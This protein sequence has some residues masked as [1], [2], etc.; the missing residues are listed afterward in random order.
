MDGGASDDTGILSLLRRKVSKII[1]F[2]AN[3]EELQNVIGVQNSEN[4][5]EDNFC[6]RSTDANETSLGCIAGLFGR[7]KSKSLSVDNISDTQYNAMRKVFPSDAWDELVSGL[8]K[9]AFGAYENTEKNTS[10]NDNISN[11]NEDIRNGHNNSSSDEDKKNNTESE[12]NDTV[13]Q[14]TNENQNQSSRPRPAGPLSY[15]LRTRV[16]PNSLICVPGGHEA[17]ILFIINSYSEDWQSL[18]P[19]DVQ[20]RMKSDNFPSRID[21]DLMEIGVEPTN[22]RNFPYIPITRL[23]YSPLLVGLLSQ[24]AS[25][26]VMQ[27]KNE[28]MKLLS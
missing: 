12:T 9:K 8:R 17:E 4:A 26:S 27:S 5:L 19:I 24:Q 1:A 25:W 11:S 20:Q 13:Y 2:C 23:S 14:C 10:N 3:N 22:L 16:L 18:L 15:T 28:I 21:E 7:M 6:D